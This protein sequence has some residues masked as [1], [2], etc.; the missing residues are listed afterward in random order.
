M[1]C[2]CNKISKR[3]LISK[4]LFTEIKQHKTKGNNSNVAQISPEE[5]KCQQG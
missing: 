1:Q 4:R 2:K 5:T 3:H